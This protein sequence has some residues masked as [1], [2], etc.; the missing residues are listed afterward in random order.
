MIWNNFMNSLSW[1]FY[2][3]KVYSTNI[4]SFFGGKNERRRT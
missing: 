1:I 4:F 2:H 3:H